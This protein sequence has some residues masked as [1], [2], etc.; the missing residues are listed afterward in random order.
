MNTSESLPSVI[1]DIL[2]AEEK[3]NPSGC[4]VR[5]KNLNPHTK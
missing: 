4:N 2:T 5:M 3:Q 1:L